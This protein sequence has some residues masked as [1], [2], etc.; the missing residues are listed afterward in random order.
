MRIASF[1][2]HRPP[3]RFLES[4]EEDS[5]TFRKYTSEL[6]TRSFMLT[7]ENERFLYQGKVQGAAKGS[8]YI[9]GFCTGKN[10]KFVDIE[11]VFPMV[12]IIKKRPHPEETKVEAP[13]ASESTYLEKKAQLAADFGTKKSKK[14]MDSMLANKVQ[15]KNIGTTKEM[16]EILSH[17]AQGIDEAM[18]KSQ[19][20]M[21]SIEVKNRYELLPPFDATTENVERIYKLND[22][23]PKD[24][25]ESI[26]LNPHLAL[27]KSEQMVLKSKSLYQTFVLSRIVDLFESF[28]SIKSEEF[29]EKFRVLL[30]LNCLLKLHKMPTTISLSE[31]AIAET[32]EIPLHIIHYLLQN[33]TDTSLGQHKDLKFTKS[34][35]NA[36]K[37]VCHI[38]VLMLLCSENFILNVKEVQKALKINT[39]KLLTY[40]KE[41]GCKDLVQLKKKSEEEDNTGSK[42]TNM[43]LR[44]PLRF[45]KLQNK[46]RK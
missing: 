22:V 17:N 34:R 45:P 12:Q 7:G 18:N 24:V 4:G 29:K 9:L 10:I 27:F 16:K 28:D 33:F 41:V 14:K 38:L 32:Y 44:A 8:K 20:E 37:L 30:Y 43:V 19:Q 3:E 11:Q 35:R 23:V 15:E 6:G 1:V 5:L 42:V 31:E 40:M 46:F 39:K 21:E 2:A 25:M 36:Y 26:D 13:E